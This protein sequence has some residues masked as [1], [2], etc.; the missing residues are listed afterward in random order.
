LKGDAIALV[1]G[2]VIW[3]AFGRYLHAWLIGMSPMG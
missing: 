2:V 1:A 3:A